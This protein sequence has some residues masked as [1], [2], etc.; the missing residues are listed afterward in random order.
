MSKI[1]DESDVYNTNS[2]AFK[3]SQKQGGAKSDEQT[4]YKIVVNKLLSD[5]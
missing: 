5:Y 1:L 3:L 4:I 2:E